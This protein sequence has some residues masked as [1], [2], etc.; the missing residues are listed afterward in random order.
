LG[1]V[2]LAS[3]AFD[4]LHYGHLKFLQEAKK[5]GGKNAR[6]VVVVASDK[7]VKRRKGKKPVLPE[8]QRKALVEALKPVDSAILGYEDVSYEKILEKVKP[9]VIAVGYDQ[10]DTYEAVRRIIEEKKLKI[11]IVKI[12][13]F[14]AQGLDSSSKIKGK[15]VTEWGTP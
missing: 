7:T 15:V 13:R 14:T 8:R 10:K 12:R 5:A 3:G 2:V 6:L 1:K 11:K 4:L 9:D